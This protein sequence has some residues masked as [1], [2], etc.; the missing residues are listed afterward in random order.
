MVRKLNWIF[1][2]T[3]FLGRP[4]AH[5]K[6][7]ICGGDGAAQ[8]RITGFRPTRAVP[9]RSALSEALRGHP[10]RRV[11][12]AGCALAFARLRSSKPCRYVPLR[13]PQEKKKFGYLTTRIIMTIIETNAKV[14]EIRGIL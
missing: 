13:P 14:S 1:S 6:I 10:P 4:Y 7:G 3:S 12:A 5:P 8:R 9:S 11:D 2:I